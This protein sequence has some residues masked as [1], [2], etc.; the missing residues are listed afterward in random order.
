MSNEARGSSAKALARF[1]RHFF[2]G[3]QKFTRIGSGSIG[4]KARGL[5]GVTELPDLKWL[6]VDKKVF[7]KAAIDTFVGNRPDVLV[8]RWR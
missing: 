2:D 8:N 4:G 5:D 3:K 7:G 1:D 6:F